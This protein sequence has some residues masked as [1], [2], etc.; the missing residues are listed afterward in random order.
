MDDRR[1]EDAGGLVRSSWVGVVVLTMT[2]AAA[3]YRSSAAGDVGSVGFVIV[4]YGA[5]LLLLRSLRAYEL[6][7]AAAA[8]D[9]DRERLRRKVWA[10]CTLLTAMFAWK[11]VGV[12][13]W[14]VAIGVWVAAAATSAAGFVLMFR[15]QQ[16]RRL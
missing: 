7:M 5:L 14:P 9:D 3:A 16:R 15:Q 8:A 10:L 12:M 13:P 2:C 11:V 1:E 6:M 4:S